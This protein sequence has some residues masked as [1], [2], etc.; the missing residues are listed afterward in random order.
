MIAVKLIMTIFEAEC[1]NSDM[2]RD[3]GSVKSVIEVKPA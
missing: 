1:G 3:N 2:N